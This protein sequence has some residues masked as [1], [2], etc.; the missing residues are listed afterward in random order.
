M[1]LDPIRVA[2]TRSWLAKATGDL[3]AADHDLTATPP[4]LEDA[5]FHVQQAAEKTLKGF[6]TEYAW[7]FRYPGDPE[8]PSDDEA[9]RALGVAHEVYRAIVAVLPHEVRP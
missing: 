7:K 8:A 9:R 3:R 6:L 5:V 2:E 4:L 1:P